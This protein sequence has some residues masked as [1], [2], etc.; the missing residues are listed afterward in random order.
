MALLATIN[1]FFSETEV[2]RGRGEDTRSYQNLG[3]YF[4]LRKIDRF[5]ATLVI[6]FQLAIPYFFY[7]LP[8]KKNIEEKSLPLPWRFANGAEH[9]NYCSEE[10]RGGR[11]GVET[12]G[13]DIKNEGHSRFPRLILILVGCVTPP[14]VRIVSRDRSMRHTAIKQPH[15]LTPQWPRGHTENSWGP[16]VN[17]KIMYLNEVPGFMEMS[18]KW[19]LEVL[20]WGCLSLFLAG[21]MF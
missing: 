5:S 11:R 17:Y 19:H 21:S 3:N 8:K 2:Y 15:R 13:V 1:L 18:K 10:P 9:L 12:R 7:V 16:W 6:Q 14:C 4:Y 20:F